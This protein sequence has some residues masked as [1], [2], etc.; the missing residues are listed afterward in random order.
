MSTETTIIITQSI[1]AASAAFFVLITA[2]VVV[3]WL[4]HIRDELR[5]SRELLEAIQKAQQDNAAREITEAVKTASGS[6]KADKTEDPELARVTA[7]CNRLSLAVAEVLEEEFPAPP[8]YTAWAQ[9]SYKEGVNAVLTQLRA[10][11]QQGR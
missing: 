4:K 5:H 8:Q 10:T 9:A 7:E 2:F 1:M 3:P 6:T 11:L